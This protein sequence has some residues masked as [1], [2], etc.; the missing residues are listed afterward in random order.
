MCSGEGRERERGKG[1]RER[2]GKR[3]GGRSVVQWGGE[4]EREEREREREGKRV[5]DLAI[6]NRSDLAQHFCVLPSPPR[7]QGFCVL[8]CA[9]KV[10]AAAKAR[11]RLPGGL[12]QFQVNAP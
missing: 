8:R 11:P 3:V 7:P 9:A 4:G 6:F 2:E 5:R 12:Q 1:E 10:D